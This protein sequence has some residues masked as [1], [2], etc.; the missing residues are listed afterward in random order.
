MNETRL[1][2]SVG[3]VLLAVA[4]GCLPLTMPC[5]AQS[6]ESNGSI[7][8]ADSLGITVA[9]GSARPS[10]AVKC[11]DFVWLDEERD[12]AVP[13]RIYYPVAPE[14]PCPI[15]LFSHGLGGSSTVCSYLGMSWAREGCVSI[16]LRHLGSD[17]SVWRGKLRVFKEL[18]MAYMRSWTGR[19]R[20]NDMRFVLD[21]LEGF[22]HGDAAFSSLL[23]LSRVG[24]A[25]YNLGSLASLMLAGQTPPDGGPSLYDPRVTAVVALGPPVHATRS[26]FLA[27]Y[28]GIDIPC[29]FINGTEDDSRVGTTTAS[30]RRIPYD[31]IS[32]NEQYLIWLRGADHMSYAGHFLPRR[33]EGDAAYQREIARVSTSFWAA[34]LLD[35]P[36]S[37]AQWTQGDRT[38]PLGSL[39]RWERRVDG[40]ERH[41]QT[42]SVPDSEL[43][44]VWTV[45]DAKRKSK[46]AT[47]AQTEPKR[48]RSR[49]RA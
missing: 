34:Y 14:R 43:P 8:A 48:R 26:G 5:S 47:P 36:V 3:R 38:P 28:S 45:P 18:K 49:N 24:A 31:S 44:D 12:R 4:V 41:A 15:I 39:S 7:A 22:A 20:A 23:D 29:L 1:F 30:Q 21:R 27:D 33:S 32:R 6:P 16:H 13:F 42:V 25:G 19:D 35:D 10:Y 9:T 11:R 37:R 2:L 46:T 17:D 40:G